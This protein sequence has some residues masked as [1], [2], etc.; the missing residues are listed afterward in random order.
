[1][2]RR[3]ERR[4]RPP[5]SAADPNGL[6]IW[7][8]RHVDA[9]RVRNFSERTIENREGYLALFIEWAEARSITRPVE[10]TKP[11]L[12]RYQRHLF[13]LRKP[14][15]KPLS[16]RAQSARL[17]ALRTYFRWLARQNVILS[18]PASDLDMPRL[19][20]R[21]PRHVL[22]EGEIEQVLGLPDTSDAFGIRDRAM[23][24]TLW[25]TGMRRSELIRLSVY[26]IDVER[27]TVLVRGKG[28]RERMVPIGERALAWIEKYLGEAR[29][30][31]LVPPDQGVLFITRFGEAF[32]PD[33]LTHLIRSYID[34]AELGK[35]GSCHLFRHAMATAMLEHGADIRHIQ[36]MLGHAELGTTEIY[37]HV[38]IRKLKA[39][40]TETHPGARLAR[41]KPERDGSSGSS[42][43]GGG[44]D[45][46]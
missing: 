21:L 3:G 1:M 25:S 2:P 30:A 14:D 40:H 36:E 31:L 34:R 38:S 17:V 15:G 16:F 23:M 42:G 43:S 41:A 12:E 11:I 44:E 22:D 33:P 10:I 39:V 28:D 6:W 13:H 20:K 4:R 18:N 37:T 7:A 29:P 35:S 9:L 24:E 45:A 19:G 32:E 8:R 5:A 26:D 27:G 46:A